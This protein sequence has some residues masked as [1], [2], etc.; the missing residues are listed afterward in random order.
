VEDSRDL[1]EVVRRLLTRAGYRVRV[2]HDGAEALT[3][4]DSGHPVDLVITDVVMPGLTGPELVEQLH[5]R[6]PEL[7]VIYTSGYTAGMLGYRDHVDADA[8]LVEK[9]FTN[10]RL[11]GAV[12]EVCS[13][14]ERAAAADRL[15]SQ[16][17]NSSAVSGRET[18]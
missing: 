6:R 7:P 17:P 8:V 16:V 3:V 1:G 10:D 13:R 14:R 5:A 15:A 4:I 9:P 12:E 11:L 2:T 18:R